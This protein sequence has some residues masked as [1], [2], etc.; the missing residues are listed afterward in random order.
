MDRGDDRKKVTG[1]ESGTSDRPTSQLESSKNVNDVAGEVGQAR[2]KDMVEKQSGSLKLDS[3]QI[4][5][6]SPVALVVANQ[7]SEED[8]INHQSAFAIQ[9]S[10][11]VVNEHYLENPGNEEQ[12]T[13][14]EAIINGLMDSFWGRK[15]Y[16]IVLGRIRR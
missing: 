14:R 7:G 6:P 8:K 9:K 3:L 15:S 5:T 11:I 13:N 4:G 1:M 16:R 2:G 12:E 10:Q